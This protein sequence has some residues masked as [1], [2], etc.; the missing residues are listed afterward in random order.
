LGKHTEANTENLEETIDNGL[1]EY[2]NYASG[3]STIIENLH[4]RNVTEE[5]FTRIM[6]KASREELMPWSRLRRID[7][8]FKD[9]SHSAWNLLVCFATVA[10]MNPVL[11]QMNQVAGFRQMLQTELQEGKSCSPQPM[12]FTESIKILSTV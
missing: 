5:E 11:K 4:K 2:L 1:S 12:T 9:V 6:L 8:L 7:K 3:F 10:K